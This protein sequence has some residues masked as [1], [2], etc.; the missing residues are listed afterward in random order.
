MDEARALVDALAGLPAGPPLDGEAARR[1]AAMDPA[2]AVRALGA[3][4]AAPWGERERKALLALA[5]ALAVGELPEERR[6]ALRASALAEGVGAV[7]A[8]LTRAT[9]ERLL[10]DEQRRA[11]AG[12]GGLTLGHRKQLARRCDPGRME[13]LALDAEPSVI[14]NLLLNPRATEALAV[15]VAA[16]RPAPAAVLEE[17][18]RSA[19]FG[20]RP[21][22]RRALALNPWSPPAVV[23]PLL[24]T[25]G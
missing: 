11:D 3:L 13:R 18:A 5:R 22:V 12:L 7:A 23:N 25:L 9:A 10:D 14:R 6:E 20:V 1:L 8:L 15:R 17:V 2:E 24:A 21:S 4:V 16:R 19:R